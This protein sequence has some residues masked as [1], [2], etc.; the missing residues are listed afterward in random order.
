MKTLFRLSFLIPLIALSLTGCKKGANSSSTSGSSNQNIAINITTEPQSL[1][2]RKARALADMNLIRMFMEGLTRIDKSG[3]PT[4]A[5]AKKMEL[6][7]DLMTYTFT[8]KESQWSN[9][10]Q[11]TAQDFAY[12]WKKSLS[13]EFNSP[14]ANMLYV[15]KNAKEAKTGKLPLSLVGIETPDA[16]TLVVKLNHPTPYFLELLS[17]PIYFS[18]NSAVDRGNSHWAEN[19]A[20]YVG[21]GPFLI[22]EWR[23]HNV[24][25]AKKNDRYWD[26]KKVKISDLRMVMVTEDTGFNMFAATELNWDGSPFSTIPVDAIQD[27]REKEKLQIVPVLATQWIRINVEHGSLR[28]KKLRR[29]L[30][31]AIDRQALVDHIAQGNQ[32]PA[33]GIVPL[34]MGLQ[35]KPFFTDGDVAMARELFNEA[36]EELG[37]TVDKLTPITLMYKG[38]SANRNHLISQA[39][40]EQWRSAFGIHIT[41][42]SVEHKVFFDRVSKRDYSLSLGN[43]FADFN[44]P[45]NF[46]EVFKSKSVGTNNTNWE[47]PSYAELLETSSYCQDLSERRALLKQSEEIIIGEMPVIPI[48]HFTMHYIH[49]SA[50]KDV[51]LTSMG[52]IDFKYAHLEDSD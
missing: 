6:S 12:A 5:L 3:K 22:H 43:W 29:A 44:D 21:N 4:L 11:L 52:S 37:T 48:F 50:L 27:L 42:E 47:N 35:T 18:V 10:D 14:N 49:D 13:P 25:D 51:L 26:K 41:L 20:T 17:N 34:A 15:I 33:T 39:I 7:D 32:I 45:I 2:P 19:H 46:L 24:I 16:K 40:Q 28:S 38:S 31:F 1:D 36:L 23:H 30:A 9:G 8:L